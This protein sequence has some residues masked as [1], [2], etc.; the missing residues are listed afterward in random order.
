MKQRLTIIVGGYIGLYPTGGVTW[1]YLQYPLG[2][3]LMG[4]DVYYVEDTVQYARYQKE[5]RAWDDASDSILYLKDVMER[6]GFKDR[7]AYRDIASGK[8]F[9]MSLQ[10][11]HEVCASADIFINISAS[12]FLREEYL[13]IPVRVLID[14]DPMFTQIDYYQE[15]YVKETTN[16][17]RMKFVVE[18]HTHHFTFGENIGASDCLIPEFGY[19]WMPTRQPLCLDYWD[20]SIA[21]PHTYTFTTIMNWSVKPD[22][23]YHGSTWGQKNRELQKFIHLP[24][25]HPAIRFE[26]MLAGASAAILKELEANGWIVRNALEGVTD[27]DAYRQYI[28]G[29]S[30]EFAVAKETYVKSRSGWFSCRSACYLAAAKPVVVQDTGWSSIIPA[31]AGVFAFEGMDALDDALGAITGRYESQCRFARDLAE[32]FFDSNEVLGELLEYASGHPHSHDK[33][34]Q[35]I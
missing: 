21:K 22:M 16:E 6:F 5:N 9:G 32:A 30:G 27:T 26:L 12:T 3:R 15:C 20:V 1:D 18:N 17:Y 31:G 28:Y 35:A 25:H 4:H 29:S 14:S 8:C 11:I 19:R 10:R 33:I 13:K 23:E 24:K 34:T 7:W 2:L